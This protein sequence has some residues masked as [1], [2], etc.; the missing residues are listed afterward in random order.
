[1][2][3]AR[4]KKTPTTDIVVPV[5]PWER[6][7]G[8]SA[9]AFEAWAIY[10]D[11]GMDRS[12]TNLAQRLHE[13][14]P[15]RWKNEESAR[16]GVAAWSSRHQ[17]QRR[18]EQWDIAEDRR[19]RA[20]RDAERVEMEQAHLSLSR[21]LLTAALARARG[22]TGPNGVQALPASGIENWSELAR[23]GEAAVRMERLTRGL[24]TD[25]TRGLDSFA[26]SEVLSM[27]SDV[28]DD[29]LR[30]MVEEQHEPFLQFVK[31]RTAEMRAR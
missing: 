20:Q 14:Y 12:L 11:M 21:S 29:A 30:R 24:P 9:Q 4:K 1:M 22:T 23:V 5:E 15:R 2:P 7:P 18:L 13:A 31:L 16:A 6:Q 17:W 28:V 27:L 25:L 3:T 10:R 26:F 19:R 8:E